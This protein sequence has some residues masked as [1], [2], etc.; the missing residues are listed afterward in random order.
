M[1]RLGHTR[2]SYQADH[3]LLTADTFVRTRLPGMENAMAIVHV[4]PAVG[5][6]FTQYTAEFEAAGKLGPTAAQRFLFVLEG[7]VEVAG[8]ALAPDHYAY[9]PA[10]C[11]AAVA[12]RRRARAEVIEKPYRALEGVNPPAMLVANERVVPSQPL[13]DDG[14]LQVRLLLP[15]D[16]AFDFAVNTMTYQP[17]AALPMVEMHVMEHGLLMLA[18]GGIYRLGERWYPVTAGDFIWMAPFCPQWFGALGKSPAKYL[19]YKDWNR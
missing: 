5:A 1:H 7:E 2:S 19:V 18:G 6:G 12:A 3:L 10:G 9:L 11:D 14:D 8:R 15:D 4:S 17:G 13:T 16:P